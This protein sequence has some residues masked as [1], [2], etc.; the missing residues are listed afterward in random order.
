MKLQAI[1][2][3]SAYVRAQRAL[4]VALCAI[5]IFHVA[6]QP[7]IAQTG[8]V[9]LVNAASYDAVVAPGSIGALFG[10]GMAT[11]T[12]I[13]SSVPLPKTLGGVTVK[14]NGL[15]APLFFVSPNQINLQVPGGVA[16]GN[17][18]IQV[19]NNGIAAAVGTG[20]ANVAEAAPGIL[21]TDLSGKNQAIALNSDFSPNSDFGKLPGARPEASGNVVV[22]YATGIGNTN[23]PVADGAPAPGNPLAVATGAT[24]VSIGGVAAEV[25]FSGLAPGFVGLWQI[26]VVIPAS[27]PTNLKTSVT[28]SLKGRQSPVTTLAVVNRNE[29]GTVNGTVFNAVSGAPL[30]SANITLQP[31][32]S[33]TTRTATTDALGKFNLYVINPGSYTLSAAAN[34]FINA[35]QTATVAGGQTGTANFALTVPL[36]AGQFRVIVTWQSAIDLDA[37]ITGPAAGNSRFHVWW[38]EPTDLLSPVTT[39]LDVDGGSPGPE[40]VTLTPNAAGSYRFSIH[41]YTNRDSNGSNGIAQS[42]VVVRVYSGN[43]Q[44]RVFTAPT[45]GGTLWKVFELTGGQLNVINSMADEPDSSNIKNSF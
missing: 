34:G 7:T 20:T 43:Q 25:Q 9:A 8:T 6:P 36:A 13:A 3:S 16:V 11:Q 23:P 18:N 5:A 30:A 32:G 12:V 42:G 10:S 29:F 4:I 24:S 35:S 19:F 39:M 14:I 28:V 26:N 37:H 31:A 44:L 45:G 15:D 41:N 2:K 33:G 40:T 22:I 27:L 21:T 38:L 17:A 1:F